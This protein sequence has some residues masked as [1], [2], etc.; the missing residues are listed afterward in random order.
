MIR[1]LEREKTLE[2]RVFGRLN[3]LRHIVFK[4]FHESAASSLPNFGLMMREGLLKE[5]IDVARWLSTH[6]S[7][8]PSTHTYTWEKVL[9]PL[10]P[11]EEISSRQGW[12]KWLKTTLPTFAVGQTVAVPTKEFQDKLPEQLTKFVRENSDKKVSI[13][14]VLDGPWTNIP[15]HLNPNEEVLV[16]E[17]M[18]TTWKR[19]RNAKPMQAVKVIKQNYSKYTTPY[20]WVGALDGRGKPGSWLVLPAEVNP[21]D[22]LGAHGSA[23]STYELY[24]INAQGGLSK[25]MLGPTQGDVKVLKYDEASY[26]V[27]RSLG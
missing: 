19:M 20:V 18:I 10:L 1:C 6:T 11:E 13:P 9:S 21:Q 17:P 22:S 25:S 2:S 8:V 4:S 24:T 23:S 27:L 14:R 15:S 26:S 7:V 5:N 12:F 3:D 16:G